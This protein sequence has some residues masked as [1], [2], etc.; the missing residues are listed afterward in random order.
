MFE[1]DKWYLDL[2]TADGAAVVLYSAR[3][4]WGVLQVGYAGRIVSQDGQV[5]DSSTVREVTAPLVDGSTLRWSNRLLA[6]EGVWQ[7]R[8]P[9]IERTLARTDQGAIEWHCH[10]PRADVRLMLDDRALTGFGYVERLQLDMPPWQLPF[11]RLRWGRHTS[12]D[13]SVVWIE[14]DDGRAGRWIWHNGADATGAVLGDHRVAGLTGDAELTFGPDATVRDHRVLPALAEW[15][16]EPIQRA[17]GPLA[18]MHERRWLAPSVVRVP[19]SA[20]DP[21]WTL[22]EEVTW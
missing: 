5:M 7:R 12:A 15:L 17:M 14:W 20:P 9:P 1:L 22:H 18:A 11:N 4:H 10:M 6:V 13:H 2:V 19:G 8:A 16:P 21:G 3:L